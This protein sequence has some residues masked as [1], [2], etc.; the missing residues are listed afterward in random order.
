MLAHGVTLVL[1]FWTVL[2]SLGW[3]QLYKW[4]RRGDARVKTFED[5]APGI[6]ALWPKVSLIVPA[7]NEATT[8]PAALATLLALDYPNLQ[9]VIVDDRSTDGT[10]DLV[11]SAARADPRIRAVRVDALPPGWIGKVHAQARGVEAADGEWLLFTDADVLFAPSALKRAVAHALARALD[12]LVIVARGRPPTFL[13]DVVECSL[14]TLFYGA[15]GVAR[16]KDPV[17]GSGQFSLVR[18]AALQRTDGLAW[19]KMEPSDDFGLSLLLRNAGAVQE[20][21]VS[22]ADISWV[23]YPTFGSMVTGFEKNMFP[24]VTGYRRAP[25]LIIGVGLFV[26]NL[27]PWLAP[28][29]L[30]WPG[31]V[32][33]AAALLSLAVTSVLRR[34]STGRPALAHFAAPVGQLVLAVVLVRA[35]FVVR[36]RGGLTWR[37]TF[38]SIDALRAGQ[39]VRAPR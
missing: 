26:L 15:A 17:V 29:V 30:G 7:M 22:R 1:G 32:L 24:V 28:F 14:G 2:A 8:L 36:R 38:Y 34:R 3:L 25:A 9:I 27:G 11:L 39:R 12:Q 13:L 10:G 6:P 18:R 5:L 23:W 19:L 33:L 35:M 21:L 16:D 37:D 20:V 4:V 31:M